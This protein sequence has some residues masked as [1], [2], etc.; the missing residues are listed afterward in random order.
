V[1]SIIIPNLHS[2]LIDQVVAAIERQTA[3][4]HIGEIIVVGQDR[5]GKIPASARSVATPAPISAAAARNLGARQAAGEHVLFLDADCLA[6]PD[7]VERLL[8]RHAQ[9][10]AVVGGAMALEA[11][12]YW[13][14]CDN[15]LSFHDVLVSAAAGARE[16]LPSFCLRLRRAL[17]RRCRRRYGPEP[18][19]APAWPHAVLRPGCVGG[20]PPAARLGAGHV[21]APA[22]VWPRLL[23]GG[24]AEYAAAIA[25]AVVT[26]TYAAPDSSRLARAGM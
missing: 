23:P 2:P 5:F 1:I 12:S 8:A 4:E 3:R 16:Y 13:V 17:R 26:P 20:A 24:A 14:L 15:L 10:Y 25:I 6:A 22:R 7:L 19:A 21:A 9:G 11:D 18:A